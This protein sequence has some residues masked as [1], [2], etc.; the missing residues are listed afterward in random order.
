LVAEERPQF[1]Q[2]GF[3]ELQLIV[4]SLT[5]QVCLEHLKML[6]VIEAIEVSVKNSNDRIKLTW[7]PKS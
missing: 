1:F 5:Y 6:V 4:D 7:N 3:A 2:V